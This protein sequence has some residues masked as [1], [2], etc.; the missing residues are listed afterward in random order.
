MPKLVG[1]CQGVGEG[2]AWGKKSLRMLGDG[3]C[4]HRILF[5]ERNKEEVVLKS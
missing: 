5:Q 2:A 1:G 4:C 3:K